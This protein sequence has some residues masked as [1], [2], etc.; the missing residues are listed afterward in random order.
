MFERLLLDVASA[1]TIAAFLLE[2]WRYWKDRN[3]GK[4]TDDAE[5]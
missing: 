4:R 3:P 5:E 2:A 1:A